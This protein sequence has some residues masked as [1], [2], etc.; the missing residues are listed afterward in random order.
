MADAGGRR[1][2]NKSFWA[3]SGSCSSRE[4]LG[5]RISILVRYVI[6]RR[7]K[8]CSNTFAVANQSAHVSAPFFTF[9]LNNG[10]DPRTCTATKQIRFP[11]SARYSLTY[12]T[13]C[14]PSAR[15]QSCPCSDPNGCLPVKQV[16]WVGLSPILWADVDGFYPGSTRMQGVGGIQPW[17]WLTW[18][19]C[20]VLMTPA[21]LPE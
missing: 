15:P 8:F 13:R 9:V 10:S 3:G 2:S 1:E 19:S 12:V 17:T 21:S 6:G 4:G 18:L 5:S 14:S 16:E 20:H 7:P 11:C